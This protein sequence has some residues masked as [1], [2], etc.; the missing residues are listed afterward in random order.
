MYL[1]SYDHAKWYLD[2]DCIGVELKR[3][4]LDG[5]LGKQYTIRQWIESN[6]QGRVW[7]WNRVQTPQSGQHDWGDMIMPQGDGVFFF[8]RDED[9]ILFT[10]TW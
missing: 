1:T 9:R 5:P 6:C 2:P 3:D 7:M 10:L 8:E 4:V